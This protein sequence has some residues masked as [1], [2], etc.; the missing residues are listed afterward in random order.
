MDDAIALVGGTGALGVGL[1]TR[2]AAAGLSVLIGS[3]DPQRA[4]AAADRI[5][6]L[7]PNARIEGAA[8]RD[9]VTCCPR[10][11]LCLPFAG[12]SDWLA[13]EGRWLVGKL[14]IDAVV[15]LGFEKGFCTLLPVPGAPSAGESIQQAVPGARV[16]CAFKN[17][18]AGPLQDLTVNLVADVLLCGNEATAR[19]EVAE[20][21]RRIPSLRPVD[22]GVLANARYLE[23][24]TALLVNVN[25]QH[26]VH[27]TIAI[28]DL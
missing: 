24:I 22:A 16:V 6:G 14:V 20:L 15:P 2:F 11:L 17:L 7:V 27:A 3:R 8:N 26:K 19:M 18:P 10:V 4:D 5:R 12:L 21:V 23:A 1:A 13:E 28:T 9:A 25:R